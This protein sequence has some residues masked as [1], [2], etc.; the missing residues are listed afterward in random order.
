MRIILAF[1]TLFMAGCATAPE[2]E[3][4]AQRVDL[5][6][7]AENV[8]V[9]TTYGNI[10]GFGPYPSNGLAVRG[11]S[12]VVLVDSGWGEAQTDALLKRIEQTIGAPVVAAVYTH[13]HDD[14][15][16]GA[17]VLDAAEIV[18]FATSLTLSIADQ[19]ALPSQATAFD[20]DETPK[21]L[22]DAGL[23]A[24]FPGRGH[25]ADNLVVAHGPSG[26]LFGG[27]LIRAGFARDMGNTADGDLMSWGSSALAAGARFPD[28][29]I[30]VP[31]HG[32]TGDRR[33]LAH[34]NALAGAAR[35]E[36]D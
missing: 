15:M 31:G 19:K 12:G 27:C 10:P 5:E 21:P 24:F 7:I 16:A 11:P 22:L 9:H 3:D 32:A 35:I 23:T 25:S 13:A 2:T 30:I 18:T 17:P 14:R 34:T 8:W 4:S 28:A 20:P 29:S 36:A 1:C 26:V 6:P 33:L